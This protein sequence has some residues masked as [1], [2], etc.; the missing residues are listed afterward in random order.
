MGELGWT[1][2]AGVV[3]LAAWAGGSLLAAAPAVDAT[4]DEVVAHLVRRRRHLLAGTALVGLGVTLLLWPLASVATADGSWPAL[5]LASL[6]VWAVGFAGLFAAGVAVAGLAWRA[7]ADLP[8]VVVRVVLDTAHLAV[9]P[10]SAP[11]GAVATVMTTTLGVRSDVADGGLATLLVVLAGTKVV[12]VAVEV[13]GT[14]RPTGWNAGGWAL[15]SSGCVSVAWFA[16]L[17]LAL[18]QSG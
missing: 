10:L 8:V 13:A 16:A 1:V 15:G 9:W 3:G 14:G 12:T 6:A 18:S 2:A 5:G 4:N 7:P 11:L 17:L